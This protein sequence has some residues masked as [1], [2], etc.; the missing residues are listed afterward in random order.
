VPVLQAAMRPGSK[1]GR[2]A[3][4]LARGG[5][6]TPHCLPPA[7]CAVGSAPSVPAESGTA[8][9]EGEGEGQGQ[10]QGEG[11][12]QGQGEGEGQGQG[13]GQGPGSDQG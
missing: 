3:A 13:P 4:S 9:G 5:A 2:R 1:Q 10:G 11:E 6:P 8:P 7:V 12:G